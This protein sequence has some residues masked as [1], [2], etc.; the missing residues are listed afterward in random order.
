MFNLF[1]G[2]S[3]RVIFTKYSHIFEI[4]K[5]LFISYGSFKTAIKKGG[6]CQQQT[7]KQTAINNI[8]KGLF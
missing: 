8:L 2:N 1:N 4:Y 5:V 7:C 6:K 3:A